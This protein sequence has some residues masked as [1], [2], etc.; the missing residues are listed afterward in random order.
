M[1]AILAL[2]TVS[3]QAQTSATAKPIHKRV[4]KKKAVESTTEREIRE[5]REQMQSQQAQIDTLKQQ[6]AD[7]DAK[8]ATAAQATQAAN[9]AAVQTKEQAES[10]SSSVQSNTA[11][12]TALNN[13][14]K[15][16]KSA[17]TGMAKTIADTKNDLTKKIDEPLALHYKGIKITPIAFFAFE[18]V[19]RQRAMNAGINTPFTSTPFANAGN[20]HMSEF[21]FTGRQS[22]IGG[23]FEGDAHSVKF[24]GYIEA[25]FLSSGTTSNNNQSNSYTLRQRQ[26]WGQAGYCDNSGNLAVRRNDS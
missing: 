4:V 22:R 17:N 5:L 13:D 18:T 19:W 16:L 2:C 21:N 6:N 24:K 11:A 10:V 25:D 8:L 7:K 14:V 23:L 12:V 20:A 26:F 9:A 15:D 3:M 1:A